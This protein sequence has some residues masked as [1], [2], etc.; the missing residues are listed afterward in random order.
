MLL[1]LP[2]ERDKEKPKGKPVLPVIHYCRGRPEARVS[3]V[4]ASAEC[5]SVIRVPPKP[6]TYS[7]FIIRRTRIEGQQLQYQET[8]K[9]R[10]QQKKMGLIHDMY[11]L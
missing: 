10:C 2:N 1:A 3:G 9:W 7:R 6:N 4:G 5:R 8:G 11:T